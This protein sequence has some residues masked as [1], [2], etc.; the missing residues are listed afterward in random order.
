[1]KVC[2]I[3]GRDR[4]YQRNRVLIKAL[5]NLG[6]ELEVV[7]SSAP[8]YFLR[9]PMVLVRWLFGTR[10]DFDL[11]FVGFVG[12]PLVPVIKC[13]TRRPII[14][15]AYI[16]IFDTL[17][18]DRKR[19][20]PDSL[21]GKLALALDLAACT[22]ADRVILDTQAHIKYFTESLGLEEER[23]SR[24]LVGA[25]NGL[26]YPSGTAR[27]G[28]PGTTR[29]FYYCT[30][31]PLH[32]MDVILDAMELLRDRKDINFFL[33]GTGP[34]YQRLKPRL[35]NALRTG[36]CSWIS[37]VP[38]RELPSHI[39][40]SDICLGGHFANTPKASRVIPCKIYQFMAMRKPF[41]AGDN[42]ANRE[43]LQHEYDALLVGMGDPQ[44]LAQAILTLVNDKALR[45]S[46][47]E[48]G[49]ATFIERCTPE[50]IA[51]ELRP[52]MDEAL[53]NG[54]ERSRLSL[55]DQRP[56]KKKAISR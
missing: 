19:F 50:V 7:T 5:R 53:S 20:A 38:E 41:I 42:P 37:W 25:D 18:N 6:I 12:H 27:N 10:K 23:F 44:A 29:V 3:A 15:D 22:M 34:E 4:E 28:D 2:Y 11:Y 26:Y 56:R 16:S 13:L 17:C 55:G 32:G 54:I 14:F 40:G 35:E 47:A 49:Y 52:I 48:K 45:Y 31:Q 43:L 33:I 1:M 30:F 46:L 36:N 51:G 8:H 21:F 24:I 9:F 39:A